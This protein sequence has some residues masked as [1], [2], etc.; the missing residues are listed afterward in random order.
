VNVAP[1]ALTPVGQ[2]EPLLQFRGVSKSFGGIVALSDITFALLPG[3]IHA[4]AG[5]NGAGKST[6]V[7]LVAGAYTPDAGVLI[8]NGKQHRWLTPKLARDNGIA[9][10]HQ[11]FNLLP[12]LSVS[13]NV[14]LGALPAGRMKTISTTLAHDQTTRILRRLGSDIDPHRLVAEFAVAEQQIIEIAKALAI[15][16][17]VIIFDEPSTVLSGEELVVLYDVLRR[18]R[19]E[20]RGLIYISHRLDEVFA[21][22]DRVTVFKDG[23]HVSTCQTSELD[24]DELIRRMVGRP[25]VEMFPQRRPELGPPM[26]EVDGV[27]VP[28]KISNVSLSLRQGEIVGLAGLGGSGRTTLARSLVG[29]EK[30]S[31]G[32]ILLD[33]M[34]VPRSPGACARSG[35]VMVPEDRKAHGILAG[36]SVA[37]NLSLA[38]LRQLRKYRLLSAKAEQVLAVRL[39]AEFDIRPTTPGTKIQNLS[40]GNQQKVVLARWLAHSP[41]VVVLDEPTRGV[42]VGAKI[43]IYTLIEKLSE[44]GVSVLLASSE[45]SEL[46]GTC[47]RVLVFREGTLV[48]EMPR[49]VATEEAIVRAMTSSS[50]AVSAAETDSPDDLPQQGAG[51]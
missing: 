44:A 4:I 26:L 2:T 18:L 33:G 9:V 19:D 10:V 25:L 36:H 13:E 22:A 38:S 17:R 41:K 3:E 35:L 31:T 28:G 49:G 1:E 40:G 47:D 8:V 37:F 30:V 27:T 24:R 43:E 5:E 32:R 29:L 14:F 11:D 12:D 46:L 42:D 6:F 16:A 23:R 7:K 34:P 21:L 50:P 39:I 20:G 15:D 51:P 45:L 48:A